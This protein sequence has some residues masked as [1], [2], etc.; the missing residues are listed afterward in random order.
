MRWPTLHHALANSYEHQSNLYVSN[1]VLTSTEGTK[2]G[3]PL[4]MA[5]FGIGIIPLIELMQKP[6][7]T[8]KRYADDES[9]AGDLKSL[10]A[11]QFH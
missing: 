4:A 2:Q 10:R 6:N 8:Q 1:T 9:A 3:D 11:I 7:V 5:I